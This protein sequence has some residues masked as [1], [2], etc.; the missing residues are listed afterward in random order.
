MKLSILIIM[1]SLL[2][3][4]LHAMSG[5]IGC[6]SDNEFKKAHEYIQSLTFKELQEA[7]LYIEGMERNTNSTLRHIGNNTCF[8]PF[9]GI[10]SLLFLKSRHEPE[11]KK[12]YIL[13]CEKIARAK[14]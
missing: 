2:S 3:P 9:A 6:L 1:M 7:K 8:N 11:M 5:L 10:S 14:L 4:Y 13:I 12:M